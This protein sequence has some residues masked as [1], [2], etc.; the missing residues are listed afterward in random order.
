MFALYDSI[1]GF[2]YVASSELPG[3]DPTKSK[4]VLVDLQLRGWQ[5]LRGFLVYNIVGVN[6]YK[7]LLITYK[8]SPEFFVLSFKLLLLPCREGSRGSFGLLLVVSV[9]SQ[10]LISSLVA[11][12][13]EELGALPGN[14]FTCSFTK[15]SS[16]SFSNSAMP[17]SVHPPSPLSGS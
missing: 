1:L 3:A 7:V 5:S 8:G 2:L 4:I 6:H 17:S 15:A 16:I 9:R 13:S 11:R 10:L 14:E 12:P